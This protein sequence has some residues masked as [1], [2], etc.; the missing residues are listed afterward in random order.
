MRDLRMTLLQGLFLSLIVPTTTGPIWCQEPRPQTDTTTLHVASRLVVV[1]VV[2]LDRNGKFVPSL[3]R[4]QFTVT[5]DKVP[6]TI[7]NF[8]PPSGHE[9]PPGSKDKMVVQS[10]ADLPKIGN[11][12]V[13]ILVF[14][15]VNT[16]FMQLAYARQAMERYLKRM[17]EVLPV[18]TLFVAA[19]ARKMAVLH[20]YTQSRSELLDSIRTHTSDT[21]F[22][23]LTNTLNG[24]KSGSD[25]GLVKTLG[26]LTQIASSV[27][28]VPGRKN[29]I[30]VGTGYR[31]AS[32]L[33]NL[34]NADN[35]KV[36][37]AIQTV[38]DRMQS[39]HVTLYMIDPEG[40]VPRDPGTA[41]SLGNGMPGDPAT[42]YGSYDPHFGFESLVYTTGGR[43]LAG[44]NDVDAEIG[45]TAIE[46]T[47]YYTLSYVPT[48]PNDVSRPY[49][50]IRVTVND[51]SLRVISRDGYFGGEEKVDTVAPSI[52]KKQPKQLLFDLTAA[53]RTTLT[54]NGL[55]IE[56]VS[57]K[58][59]Y[60]LKVKA[61][62]LTWEP[63]QDGS[64]LAEVTVVAV[65]YNNR[66]K[67]VGQ[68]AAELKQQIEASDV[69]GPQSQVGFAFPF[70]L[71]PGTSR[72]R[73]VVRD[74]GTGTMGS[75]NT[76]P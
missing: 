24:G 63:Q 39:A 3:D 43:I 28:G 2:V 65:G 14:D 6:Q 5:E 31:N 47:M 10:S 62:D 17:P 69:I 15:E 38:T 72:V 61:A 21:D 26:A 4:S 52:A 41:D 18:P 73:I 36:K 9:M 44:R 1:D 57:T 75:A 50:K 34:S 12:P 48:S 51:S 29:I 55:H 49:R 19:G 30:W 35:D 67:E 74:A 54:Y 70:A 22:T 33:N 16:P 32:D 64:R 37:A 58:N 13:N 11:A 42:G 20:D 45:Q 8:D 46:G 66:D 60:L 71:P 27:R 25:D 56:P 59:G 68:H 23:M 76:K 40:I 7:K 53:A